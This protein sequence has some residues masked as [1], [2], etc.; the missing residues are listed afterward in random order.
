MSNIFLLCDI[1]KEVVDRDHNI[2]PRCAPTSGY[3][4]YCPEYKR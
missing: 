4:G 2:K 1:C 3:Y